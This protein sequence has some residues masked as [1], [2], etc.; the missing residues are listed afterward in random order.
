LLLYL[1][2]MFGD[3]SV[4]EECDGNVACTS[5]ESGLVVENELTS[6]HL[7]G[8]NGEPGFG[9]EGIDQPDK[10]PHQAA[11]EHQCNKARRLSRTSASEDV[12]HAVEQQTPKEA[13]DSSTNQPILDSL[14]RPESH[15]NRES[16]ERSGNHPTDRACGPNVI[17]FD[18]SLKEGL[19]YPTSDSTTDNERRQR[20]N[21]SL[22]HFLVVA[23]AETLRSHQ[24]NAN[25]KH[26]QREIDRR[27]GLQVLPE[28]S[29]TAPTC[30]VHLD[31]TEQKPDNT[32]DDACNG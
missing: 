7:S 27:T 31:L 8:D 30:V 11:N 14:L 24:S 9:A 2:V 13:T 19:R 1:D 16:P 18:H 32:S 17:Q 10:R 26:Y 23:L 20:T 29:A 15:P 5:N 22:E 21:N 12:V 6:C 4:G 28:E 25:P 3:I